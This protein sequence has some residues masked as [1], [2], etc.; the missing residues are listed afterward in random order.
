MTINTEANQTARETALLVKELVQTRQQLK[1]AGQDMSTVDQQLKP[2]K[3]MY[4]GA[5]KK[6]GGNYKGMVKWFD[7]RASEVPGDASGIV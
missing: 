1:V 2:Y 7:E 6:Y 3:T 5:G 4:V